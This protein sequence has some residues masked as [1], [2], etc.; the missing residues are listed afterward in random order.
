MLG[1]NICLLVV[2][3]SVFLCFFFFQHNYEIHELPS[4]GMACIHNSDSTDYGFVGLEQ[5]RL[6]CFTCH[7][8]HSCARVKHLRESL[9]SE[10]VHWAVPLSVVNTFSQDNESVQARS[11][12]SGPM[13]KSKLPIP[14]DSASLPTHFFRAGLMAT[15]LLPSG[16]FGV[17]PPLP[18]TPCSVC[19]SP[20]SDDCPVERGWCHETATAFAMTVT[21]SCKGGCPG[22]VSKTTPHIPPSQVPSFCGMM[23]SLKLQINALHTYNTFHFFYC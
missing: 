21:F 12:G 1:N 16:G 7:D 15:C 3:L 10:N 5:K 6:K 9:S 8:M 22:S 11:A 4:S 18:V 14:F 19:H 23:L 2:G 13:C 17:V 20:W